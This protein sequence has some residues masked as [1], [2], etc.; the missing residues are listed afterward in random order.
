[1]STKKTIGQSTVSR[2]VI[3]GELI[4]NEDHPQPHQHINLKEVLQ[5]NSG[6][7]DLAAAVE[8]IL[9]Y[10]ALCHA[11]VIDKRTGKLNSASPDE[12]ALVE[13]AQRLGISFEGKSAD[14]II[15]VKRKRDEQ[16]LQ[17]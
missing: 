1:M 13:G 16:I 10:L 7:N 8:D 2:S 9:M 4:Q 14:G 6:A 12:L 15:S 17:Y 5:S 11:V 3:A